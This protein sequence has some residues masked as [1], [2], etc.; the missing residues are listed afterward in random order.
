M[1]K[2]RL[3]LVFFRYQLWQNFVHMTNILDA[4]VLGHPPWP[5]Q[6][7]ATDQV[8][9]AQWLH[10]SCYIPLQLNPHS[11]SGWCQHCLLCLPPVC[12]LFLHMCLCKPTCML[13]VIILYGVLLG[14]S[15]WW[16]VSTN[17]YVH[18]DWCIHDLIENAYLCCPMHGNSGL[19]MDLNCV[20]CHWLVVWLLA[21]FDPNRSCMPQ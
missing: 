9:L 5:E 10:S 2:V 19:H 8:T 20:L 17:S 21:H 15:L 7:N 14:T 18:I 16:R 12:I 13:W 11:L 6:H 4:L 1:H 3:S